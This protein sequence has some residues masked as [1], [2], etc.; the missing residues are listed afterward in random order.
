[1]RLFAIDARWELRSPPHRV[2]RARSLALR[3]VHVAPMGPPPSDPEPHLVRGAPLADQSAARVR[4]AFERV[5]FFD[6]PEERWIPGCDGGVW[7][8][9]GLRNGRQHSRERFGSLGDN[10][11]GW[12]F[13]GAGSELLRARIRRWPRTIALASTR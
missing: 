3:K 4:D 13:G 6:A 8:L 10:D 5:Q 12:R 7:S 2:N 9:D 11:S 1:M